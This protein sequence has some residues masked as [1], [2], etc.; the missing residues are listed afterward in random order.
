MVFSELKYPGMRAELLQYL[1]ALSD[2]KYQRI[3]WVDHLLGGGKYDEFDYA[4]HFIYDDT[5]LSED[6]DLDIGV[7]LKDKKESDSIKQLVREIDVLFECYGLAL[8]D[9]EYISKPEWQN[10]ILKAKEA[11]SVFDVACVVDLVS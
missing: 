3:A 6:P 11:C 5:N 1:Q 10:V 4:V 2:P 7:I 8:T 9:G